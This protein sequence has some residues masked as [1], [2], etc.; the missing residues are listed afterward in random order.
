MEHG[1]NWYLLTLYSSL[2]LHRCWKFRAER[3]RTKSV[4]GIF[5]K[6]TSI[7]VVRSI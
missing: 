5:R 2:G 3:K 1:C 6:Q 7:S 4:T